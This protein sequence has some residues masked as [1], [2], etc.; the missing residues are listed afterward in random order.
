MGT[1]RFT[2][3][4]LQFQDKTNS[5]TEDHNQ[6]STFP[7]SSAVATIL[8][9]N[10]PNLRQPSKLIRKM[11]GLIPLRMSTLIPASKYTY[12]ISEGKSNQTYNDRS[13]K[14]TPSR[15]RE[16]EEDRRTARQRT[17]PAPIV[18][19]KP[20]PS[21]PEQ[22]K[23]ALG[24]VKRDFNNRKYRQCSL[25]CHE[26]LGDIK[27]SVRYIKEHIPSVSI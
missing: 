16:N 7:H 15:P 1:Y 4:R 23:R 14:S 2:L 26:L 12:S 8:F 21:T 5:R 3:S 9:I 27:D 10:W 6:L 24:D 13:W 11:P 17:T 19:S 22:W 20:T 18:A 25:R